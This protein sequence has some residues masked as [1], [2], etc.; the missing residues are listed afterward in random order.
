[1]C[2]IFLSLK[3][4]GDMKESHT[5]Y[6]HIMINM[7]ILPC[8]VWLT[9]HVFRFSRCFIKHPFY[10]YTYVFGQFCLESETKL[11]ILKISWQIRI[12][13]FITVIKTI[14]TYFIISDGASIK[15]LGVQREVRK[16]FRGGQEFAIFMLK[17]VKFG[18]ILAHLKLF[19]GKRGGGSRKYKGKNAPYAPMWCRHCNHH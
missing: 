4:Q 11:N 15:I 6:M 2:A 3:F 1:M 13:K 17:I 14:F 9:H 16:N 18:L 7:S 19:L 10:M 8:Q 12:L 5:H